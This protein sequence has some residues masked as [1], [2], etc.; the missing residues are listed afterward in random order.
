MLLQGAIASYGA[1]L[2][3]S[4]AGAHDQ[5]HRMPQHGRHVNPRRDR[6]AEAAKEGRVE[7][8]VQ[9]GRGKRRAREGGCAESKKKR[10]A[11]RRVELRTTR[12]LS[13]YHTT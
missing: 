2:A 11:E 10:W 8:N 5:L 1:W 6:S 4:T 3:S 13:E 7:A 12:T 9:G